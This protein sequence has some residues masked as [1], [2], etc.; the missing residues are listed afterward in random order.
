MKLPLGKIQLLQKELAN[1]PLLN[2][3]IIQELSDIHIFMEH[4]VFAVW[5]FM[6]LIKGLQHHVC[7]S[8]TCWV[9]RQKIRSGSAR[10][11]NEI[12]FSR[13]D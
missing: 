9:P 6:S 4:H 11:I 8:T 7:P 5:D 13:R 10:L 1:H 3:N 12:V 2:D